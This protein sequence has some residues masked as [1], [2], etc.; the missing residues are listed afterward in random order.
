MSEALRDLQALFLAGVTR[1]DAGAERLIIDDNRVGAARRLDIYRNNYRAS[2]TGV[3]ADHYERLAAYVGADQFGRL[4]DAFV[5]ANPSAWRNLRYYGGELAAFLAEHYPGDGELAELAALDWAL[6]D[7]FDAADAEPLDGAA[8]AALGEQWIE[9][10]LVLVPSVHRLTV[11][12]NVAAIWNALE[13]EEA[14]PGAARGAVPET[15][16]V[17]RSA[18]PQFRTLSDDEAAALERLAGG[19]S[20]TE[21][22]EAMLERLGEEGAMQALGGWLGRWLADGLLVLADQAAAGTDVT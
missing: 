21:L 6:R 3:L 22:S 5:A 14:P 1:G 20:F 15:I 17:W 2:L 4:A 16:L 13:A 11:R 8:V 12:H 10:R 9:R 19:C 7:A 18:Q